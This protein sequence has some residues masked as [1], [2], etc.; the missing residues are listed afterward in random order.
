MEAAVVDVLYQVAGRPGR[1]PL[2]QAL[3]VDRTAWEQLDQSEQH[4]IL[5]R[6][7]EQIKYDRRLQQGRL[8]LRADR[9]GEEGEEVAIRAG[10]K[11]LVQQVPPPH[12]AQR[13]VAPPDGGLPRITKLMALAVRF[14]ELLRQGTA[15]DYADL[16]RLGGVSR[17]R[18]TQLMNLRNLAPV[19]QEQILLLPKEHSAQNKLQERTLRRITGSLDWRQQMRLFEKLCPELVEH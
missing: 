12:V 18:I 16:A 3:P 17:A 2:R 15:K 7:V 11:P 9:R 10:K 8:R 5:E 13:P 19:I 1:E 6:V 4:R 14:E